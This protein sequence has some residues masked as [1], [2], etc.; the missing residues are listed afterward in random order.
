[1]NDVFQILR[2]VWYTVTG[3]KKILEEQLRRE[4]E[5]ENLEQNIKLAFSLRKA[6]KSSNIIDQ[7]IKE[8]QRSRS[9]KHFSS[10]RSS[11][12]GKKRSILDPIEI[13]TGS[14]YGGSSCSSDSCSSSSDSSSNCD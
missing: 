1:M 12:S 4:K 2:E 5:K 9:G 14:G 6:Y 10:R 11:S 13:L 7:L 8:G 3:R